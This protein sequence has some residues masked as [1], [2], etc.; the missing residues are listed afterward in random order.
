MLK[1]TKKVNR[2]FESFLADLNIDLSQVQH[3]SE[4]EDKTITCI[5]QNAFIWV[6]GARASVKKDNEDSILEYIVE[7][8][9]DS[10]A[11]RAFRKYEKPIKRAK[12][13]IVVDDVALVKEYKIHRYTA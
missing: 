3:F 1:E 8:E 9:D 13:R 5:T 6:N 4:E 11:L 12:E 7:T 2:N 10:V